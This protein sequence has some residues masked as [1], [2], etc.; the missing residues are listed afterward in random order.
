MARGFVWIAAG[1]LQNLQ[2]FDGPVIFAA[3]HQSHMDGP[4]ILAARG[5]PRDG[6]MQ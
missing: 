5:A 4:V 1:G 3:N 2:H 6:A